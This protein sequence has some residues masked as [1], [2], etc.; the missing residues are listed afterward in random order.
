VE[1]ENIETFV[2]LKFYI[3]VIDEFNIKMGVLVLNV[4]A[5]KLEVLKNAFYISRYCESIY[6]VK[7]F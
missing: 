1:L 7:Q 2:A 5:M 6:K 4:L 3:V